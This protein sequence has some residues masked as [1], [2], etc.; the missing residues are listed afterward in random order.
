LPVI[1]AALGIT[2]PYPGSRLPILLIENP[3][4]HLHP[5]G[6]TR[7]AE[8][9][10][11]STQK[12]MQIVLETH[13]DHFIDGIRLAVKEGKISNED[14]AIHYF[15][16]EKDIGTV[17]ESP[18]L[19]KTGKLSFWP[20]GFGDQTMINRARLARTEIGNAKHIPE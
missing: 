10:A 8:L 19:S 9:I 20:E 18:E 17:A 14:V 2:I 12:N 7:M 6:Q 5:Q 3:E 16:K 13:S 1:V 15:R 4:A 11:L